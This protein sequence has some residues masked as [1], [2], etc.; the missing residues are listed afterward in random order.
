MFAS[1]LYTIE[2]NPLKDS[3]ML[4]KQDQFRFCVKNESVI[5]CLWI[6]NMCPGSFRWAKPTDNMYSFIN[7]ALLNTNWKD[8]ETDNSQR[9]KKRS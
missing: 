9:V 6:V 1:F 7:W 5:I 8:A 3:G 2:N 4:Y